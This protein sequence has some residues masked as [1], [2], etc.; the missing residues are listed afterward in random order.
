MRRLEPWTGALAATVLILHTACGGGD[1]EPTPTDP[2]DPPVAT[3]VNVSP[4]TAQLASIGA[5]VQLTATVL[6]QRGQ[7]MAGVSVTWGSSAPS[8]ASVAANGTVTAVANGPASI[9]ATSGSAS[10]SANVTVQ[11]QAVRIDVSPGT[12]SLSSIGQ[13]VQFTAEA[14]DANGH[15]VADAGFTWSSSNT[16]VATVSNSGLA[17]STG[18]GSAEIAAGAGGV[19]ATADLTVTV[20]AV[21]L[22]VS[23]SAHTMFSV[24]DT[25][26]LAAEVLDANGN[27]VP[28]ISVTWASENSGIATVDMSGLVTSVRTGSTNIYAEVGA[29]ADSAAISVAQLAVG[30]DITPEV[31]T[32]GVVG[33]TVRLFAVARDANGNEVEDTDYVWTSRHP[34][35]VTV[36]SNGLVTATGTGSGTIQVRATRAGGNYVARA[37]I[38]VLQASSGD[39]AGD[40]AIQ[41]VR[42]FRGFRGPVRLYVDGE[43]MRAS[44][45]ATKPG[46]EQEP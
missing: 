6:D 38:T 30:V 46:G 33:D 14:S 24:G 39:T 27:S 2:V 44:A 41:V 7:P 9:T 25:L 35:V 5:T 17:T 8:V 34:Q 20:E 1:S 22:D 21:A 16:S 40:A 11:Q 42:H 43:L 36:D 12:A 23:P 19:R 37:S 18:I 32:L 10:G 28:G 3:T 29:L 13:T 15:A 45:G 4:A 31:D 26:R